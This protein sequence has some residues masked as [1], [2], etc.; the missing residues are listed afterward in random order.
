M[1]KNKPS[2][3]FK[4]QNVQ[5]VRKPNAV[6]QTR[7]NTQI[8][9]TQGMAEEQFAAIAAAARNEALNA[10]DD[11]L[12][13]DESVDY[14]TPVTQTLTQAQIHQAKPQLSDSEDTN[15]GSSGPDSATDSSLETS[16][17]EIIQPQQE[18]LEICLPLSPPHRTPPVPP[19]S[20]QS[21]RTNVVADVSGLISEDE[22]TTQVVPMTVNADPPEPTGRKETLSPTP[23]VSNNV[24]SAIEL[25]VKD[26]EPSEQCLCDK[27]GEVDFQ[28]STHTRLEP[29]TSR[30]SQRFE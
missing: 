22:D 12:T 30:T 4:F 28:L 6:H 5:V 27:C 1:S 11:L 15:H 8:N 10:I 19:P 24:R 9:A 25:T 14:S 26:L 21:P 18:G 23:Q 7:Q 16:S 20:P 17:I 3:F 2:S 29:T 13:D